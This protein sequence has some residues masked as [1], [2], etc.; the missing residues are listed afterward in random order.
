MLSSTG[1]ISGVQ[2]SLWLRAAGIQSLRPCTAGETATERSRV[3]V[4]AF[5]AGLSQDPWPAN[6]LKPQAVSF[7]LSNW[8][9]NLSGDRTGERELPQAVSFRCHSPSSSAAAR[10]RCGLPSSDFR[11][12]GLIVRSAQ[13]GAANIIDRWLDTSCSSAV[14]MFRRQR[15]EK[16]GH[17]SHSDLGFLADPSIGALPSC[18]QPLLW[19]HSEDACN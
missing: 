6:N 19:L 16:K 7:L 10:L 14:G 8:K 11:C 15:Q 4:K 5:K 9:R 1:Y 12:L 17:A 18:C 2:P 3:N 13:V